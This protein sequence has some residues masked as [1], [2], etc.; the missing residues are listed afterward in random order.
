MRWSVS[1]LSRCFYQISARWR[2]LDSGCLTR[3]LWLTHTDV[4]V[5]WCGGQQVSL[6]NDWPR[7][8]MIIIQIMWRQQYETAM[9]SLKRSPKASDVTATTRNTPGSRISGKVLYLQQKLGLFSFQY[10][11]TAGSASVLVCVGKTV[12][13]VIWMKWKYSLKSHPHYQ[14]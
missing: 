7:Q 12:A 14:Q 6:L 9:Y 2:V 3:A 1:R 10:Q 11:L 13:S 5:E 8:I 4:L